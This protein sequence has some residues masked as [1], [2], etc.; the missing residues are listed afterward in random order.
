MGQDSYRIKS[1]EDIVDLLTHYGCVEILKVEGDKERRLF[2]G[3][4]KKGERNG[5]GESYAEN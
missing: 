2:E 3:V 1:Q 4:I 5:F